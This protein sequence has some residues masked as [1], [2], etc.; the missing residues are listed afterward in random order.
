MPQEFRKTILIVCEGQGTEPDYFNAL[1][2]LL[3]ENKVNVAIEIR[4]RPKSQIP[5]APF[6]VRHGG[7][8]RQLLQPGII[9]PNTQ[10]EDKYKA[11]PTRYVREAQIGLEEGTYEEVWAVY[12]KDGH[13]QHKEA[14]ELA[15]NKINGKKVNIAFNSIAFEYWIL[16]HFESNTTEFQKSLCRTNLQN[17]KKDYHFCGDNTHTLDCKGANCVCGRIVYGGYLEYEG[18]K[19]EFKFASYFANVNQAIER[20]VA[21]K[22]SYIGNSTPV[23]DLNPYTTNHRIVFKLLQ[24]PAIDYTWFESEEEQYIGN[25]SFNI[26]YDASLVIITIRK[27]SDITEIVTASHFSLVDKKGN[28]L[29]CGQR[30]VMTDAVFVFEIDLSLIQNFSPI[31]ICIRKAEGE[32]LITELPI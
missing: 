13:P 25:L 18:S 14:F 17:G 9:I 26:N 4:P 8:R 22:N 23:Y 15:E 5:L 7:K 3:I 10:I 20:A 32:Y 31:F 19:K 12:D 21:L 27:S 28:K 1:R 29:D 2:D 24:L 6:Q 16:L 11:Q 30:K